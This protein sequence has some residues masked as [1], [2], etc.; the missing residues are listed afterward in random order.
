[1]ATGVEGAGVEGAGVEGWDDVVGLDGD[2]SVG[3][4]LVGGELVC[5]PAAT[6]SSSLDLTTSKPVPTSALTA[7]LPTST[8]MA[9]FLELIPVRD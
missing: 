2:D 3:L 4:V 7:R 8:M 9:R 1:M 5:G 6:A